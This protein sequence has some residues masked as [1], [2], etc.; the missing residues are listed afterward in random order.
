MSF[1]DQ[2]MGNQASNGEAPFQLHECFFSRTD[3]RGIIQAGNYL[4]KR[5][6]G[7]EWDELKGAPHKMVRHPDMPKGLFWLLWDT[8]KRG[9]SIGAY[10][11][12]RTKDGL[13]YWVY[14][15]VVPCEGGYLSVRFKP[16]SPLL[17]TI[18]TEY[19]ALLKA[20]QTEN[21]TPQASAM[22]LLA[23]LQE[24]GF[25]KYHHFAAHAASEE[26]LARDVGLKRTQNATISNMRKMLNNAQTLKQESQG[27]VKEFQAMRTIPHNLRVIASRIEPA[28]GPVTV[29][30]QNY[31]TMSESM[32][33]WF[34]AHV[35]GE[36]SNFSSINGTVNNSLFAECMALVIGECGEMFSAEEQSLDN[37]DVDAERKILSKVSADRV[38]EAYAGLQDVRTEADRILQ[39]CSIMH[40]HLLGLSSTRVLCKIESARLPDTGETLTDIIDQLADFQSRISE[41]LDH[42]VRL[43][44]EI[45]SQ[46]FETQRVR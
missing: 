28:G 24:L 43:S 14:A 2:H 10:V 20:E 11:K 45:R 44:N 46:D 5:V 29:L 37:Q 15:M 32:S 1:H 21:L 41:K 34:E 42:I 25:D 26:L 6:A 40:R 38:T 9:R 3:E 23:R 35:L 4:F 8:I 22:R 19:E 12:N 39:A 7:F 13:Y 27:L 31:S 30:S 17:A 33:Q 18:Q 16:S 36:K